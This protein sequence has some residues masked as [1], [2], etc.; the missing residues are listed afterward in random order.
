MSRIGKKPVAVPK[1]VEVVLEGRHL[2][3]SGPK[4][5][6]ERQVNPEVSIKW[7]AEERQIV[8]DRADDSKRCK[9]LH[10]LNRALVANMVEGVVKGYSKEME[11]HGVGYQ[12]RMEGNALVLQVG[13]SHTVHLSVPE[14]LK[15]EVTQPTGP[16]RIMISG[17]DK[18]QVGQFAANVR[19]V[20]PPEPYQ[21]KGIRHAG[22]SIRRKAGKAFSGAGAT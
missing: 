19:N 21:G 16:G 15:V 8:L 2:R 14:G 17:C 22:E 6:L 7:D 13:F 12:S 9:A 1:E 4:G 11:V 3:L 20:R 5:K 18:H 10:G